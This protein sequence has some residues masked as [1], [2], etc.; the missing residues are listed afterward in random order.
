MTTYKEAAI[1]VL[2]WSK[3]PLTVSEILRIAKDKWYIV[4]QKDREPRTPEKTI[5]AYINVDMKENSWNSFFIKTNP[6]KFIYN[7][8]CTRRPTVK[9]KI[10]IQI[11]KE[12]EKTAKMFLW[13]W[14][15]LI[16]SWE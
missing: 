13:K 1:K 6:W 16:V 15:E 14:W 7:K 8:K 4:F 9:T 10:D 11:E 5:W 12:S 3:I 2:K